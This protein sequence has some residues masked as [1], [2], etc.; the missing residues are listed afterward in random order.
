MGVSKYCV[1]YFLCFFHSCCGMVFI[2]PTQAK[3]AAVV[4]SKMVLLILYLY[5]TEGDN[6][7]SLCCI[8]WIGHNQDKLAREYFHAFLG[9]GTFCFA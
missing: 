2:A 1:K 5:I 4:S 7:Y 9:I 6:N 3:E 8:D